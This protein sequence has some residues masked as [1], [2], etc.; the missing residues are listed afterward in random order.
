LRGIAFVRA[1]EVVYGVLHVLRVDHASS[2]SIVTPERDEYVWPVHG[3]RATEVDVVPDCKDYH[4]RERVCVVLAY[5]D[6]V[7]AIY[8]NGERRE[9]RY[10]GE[11]PQYYS[12]FGLLPEAVPVRDLGSETSNLG[13]CGVG[14]ESQDGLALEIRDVQ[15]EIWNASDVVLIDWNDTF[16]LDSLT[17]SNGASTT[18]V[19]ASRFIGPEYLPVDVGAARVEGQF[20]PTLAISEDSNRHHNAFVH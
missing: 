20:K 10:Q 5:L 13:L 7:I 4:D 9:Y 6:D 12:H 8:G 3:Q 19:S 11:Y 14:E 18:C 1:D 2:P 15:S 17:G 16:G